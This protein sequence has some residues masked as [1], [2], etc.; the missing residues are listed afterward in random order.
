MS[1]VSQ[2]SD[3]TSIVSKTCKQQNEGILD[4]DSQSCANQ[5][6][7]RRRDV[8]WIR[9]DI[10]PSCI[11]KFAFICSVVFNTLKIIVSGKRSRSRL[12][13]CNGLKIFFPRGTEAVG[14]RQEYVLV[15]LTSSQRW[16]S[17]SNEVKI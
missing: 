4:Y 10:P 6:Q 1:V 3:L 12:T 2:V 8:R 13:D 5:A 14:R 11:L 7:R 9:L 15:D 17:N 16:T